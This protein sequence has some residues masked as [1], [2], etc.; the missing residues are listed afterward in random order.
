MVSKL[1]EDHGL[2]SFVFS[3]VSD[4]QESTFGQLV[5][6]DVS[7][8]DIESLVLRVQQTGESAMH[9]RPVQSNS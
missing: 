8:P 4:V 7:K 9:L 5:N 1:N 3:K 6:S 2:G